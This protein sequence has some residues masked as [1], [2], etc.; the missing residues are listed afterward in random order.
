MSE[1]E[2]IGGGTFWKPLAE[3]DQIEGLYRGKE[4]RE[5]GQYGPQDVA[6]IE[7]RGGDLK[8]VTVKAGLKSSFESSALTPG[9]IV[10]IIYLGKQKNP[11]TGRTFD[12]FEVFA[13]TADAPGG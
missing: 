3:G 4:L 7:L 13:R 10:K 9:K 2:R 11:R 6:T 1:Y 5:G 12:A 8:L